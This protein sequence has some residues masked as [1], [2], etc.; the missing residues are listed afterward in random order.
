[1]ANV[2]ISVTESVYTNTQIKGN[3]GLREPLLYGKKSEY[4]GKENNQS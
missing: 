3:R 2:T 1:M 4:K